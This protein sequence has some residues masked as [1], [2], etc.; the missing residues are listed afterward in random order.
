M[1]KS[2]EDKNERWEIYRLAQ[3]VRGLSHAEQRALMF[4]AQAQTMRDGVCR[5]SVKSV[6]RF[7]DSPRSFRY[8]IH[9]RKNWR[10]NTVSFP[11]LLARGLV[12]ASGKL[13]GGRSLGGHGLTVEYTINRDMLLTYLNPTQKPGTNPAHNPEHNAEHNAAHK[14]QS[15]L[16]TTPKNAAH[17]AAQWQTSS[18]SSKSSS[19]SKAS[20]TAEPLLVDEDQVGRGGACSLQDQPKKNPPATTALLA[21]PPQTEIQ[22]AV[23]VIPPDWPAWFPH[24]C[25][26]PLLDYEQM[27]REDFAPKGKTYKRATKLERLRYALDDGTDIRELRKIIVIATANRL[28]YFPIELSKEEKRTR[29]NLAAIM[30]GVG[31]KQK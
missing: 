23:E 27:W 3:E 19:N 11:G 8:G 20:S 26:Q 17:N 1:A 16:H 2:R 30:G 13:K 4:I 7:G 28:P 6:E 25:Y 12:S 14:A 9:G 22:T 10:D 21:P 31:L 18:L 5:K 29:R 15:T 24:D